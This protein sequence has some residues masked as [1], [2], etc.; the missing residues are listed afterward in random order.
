MVELLEKIDDLKRY[1]DLD[2][3]VLE[4]EQLQV[5]IKKDLLLYERI[6]KKDATVLDDEQVKLYKKVEN[7][8]NFLILEIRKYLIEHLEEKEGILDANH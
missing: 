3:R 7:E 1:L 5:E 2:V 4:L 8:V 6:Q